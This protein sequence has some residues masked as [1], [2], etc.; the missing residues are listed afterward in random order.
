MSEQVNVQLLQNEIANLK[1]QFKVMSAQHEAT[2]QMF[3]EAAAISMQVRTN[4]HLVQ[5]SAQDLTDENQSLKK[6]IEALKTN[7]TNLESQLKQVPVTQPEC[8]SPVSPQDSE[9]TSNPN[10]QQCS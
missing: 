8:Q 5:Q 2:K 3:N 6:E 9:T 7:I 4:L 1:Q 10:L